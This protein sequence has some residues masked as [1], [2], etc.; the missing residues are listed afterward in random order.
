VYAKSDALLRDYQVSTSDAKLNGVSQDLYIEAHLYLERL[1]EQDI[2][3]RGGCSDWLSYWRGG[4]LEM[5]SFTQRATKV[6]VAVQYI[7]TDTWASM[8]ERH[9]ACTNETATAAIISQ[10]TRSGAPSEA[11]IT[12][13]NYEWVV[14]FC[15]NGGISSPAVC[16]ACPPNV[17]DSLCSRMGSGDVCTLADNQF[18]IAPCAQSVCA[19]RSERTS[20]TLLHALFEEKS[21]PPNINSAVLT[22]TSTTITAAVTL[23]DEG[24]IHCDA[25]KASAALPADTES[26]RIANFVA[27][28]DIVLGSHVANVIMLNL[29]PATTYKIFCYTESSQGVVMDSTKMTVQSAA[30]LASITTAC[31]KNMLVDLAMPSILEGTDYVDAISVATPFAPVATFIVDINLM[32]RTQLGDVALANSVIP[33]SL[34]FEPTNTGSDLLRKISIRR[35]VGSGSFYLE[36]IPRGGSGEF[37][38]TYPK[39]KDIA[40][41]GVFE[42]PPPPSILMVKF[43]DDGSCVKVEFNAKTDRAKLPHTFVCSA[44]FNF[45]GMDLSVCKWFSE[46]LVYVYP[47]RKVGDVKLAI[48]STVTVLPGRLKAVCTATSENEDPCANWVYMG[49]SSRE[50]S[51]PA[52]AVIPIV[53][54]SSSAQIGSCDSLPLD[55]TSS[56]GGGGRPWSIQ[57]TV[58]SSIGS[59]S[60]DAANIKTW[61]ET[62]YTFSP[63]KNVP[64]NLLLPGR[65]YNIVVKLCNFLLGCSQASHQVVVLNHVKPLVAIPGSILRTASRSVPFK[66]SSSA[67]VAGCGEGANAAPVSHTNI[68]LAWKVF[69]TTG[70]DSLRQAVVIQSASRDPSIMLLPRFTLQVNTLYEFQ[71]TA[72]SRIYFSSAVVSVKVLVEPS[73]VQAIILG[74]QS[75]SI[76]PLGHLEL[77][78]SDSYDED[79]DSTA[80][81]QSAKTAM[82]NSFV[83]EWS[84]HQIEPTLAESCSFTVSSAQPFPWIYGL[85]SS[86]VSPGTVSRVTVKITHTASGRSSSTDV[87]VTGI[88]ATAALVRASSET[89]LYINPEK[90]IKL[91]GEIQA[92]AA[93]TATW[94]IKGSGVENLSQVAMGSIAMDID[95]RSSSFYLSL[96]PNAIQQGQSYEFILTC[97]M[98]VGGAVSYASVLV[99]T[100]APPRPGTVLVNPYSGTEL[101][102]DFDISASLWQDQDLPLT[103]SLFYVDPLSKDASVVRSRSENSFG[104][105]KLPAGIA[106]NNFKVTCGV[107]VYDILDAM[108]TLVDENVVVNILALNAQELESLIES[109]I[110]ANSAD[111]GA[112]KQVIATGGSKMNT[113]ACSLAPDCAAL[114]RKHCSDVDHTCGSCI[115][116]YMG[117]AGSDNSPCV[118][119][120]TASTIGDA[121]GACIA[122]ADCPFSS[123]VSSLCIPVPEKAC[124][125]QCS[126]NGICKFIDTNTN[127]QLSSCSVTTTTCVAI[128][129][130]VD[131]FFGPL[132]HLL[133]QDMRSL[134]SARA[135][136][137]GSFKHLVLSEDPSVENAISWITSLKGLTQNPLELDDAA[138]HEVCALISSIAASARAVKLPYEQ[139]IPIFNIASAIVESVKKTAIYGSSRRKLSEDDAAILSASVDSISSAL[140]DDMVIGQDS[141]YIT[142]ENFRLTAVTSAVP[143]G[144]NVTISS[145]R[146]QLETLSNSA[147]PKIALSPMNTSVA[148]KMTLMVTPAKLAHSLD[149]SQ[150]QLVSIPNT[151]NLT[152]NLL[153]MRVSCAEGAQDNRVTFTI[154]HNG[155]EYFGPASSTVIQNFTTS[156]RRKHIMTHY[157]HCVGEVDTI[158]EVYCDG[159][160]KQIFSTCPQMQWQPRCRLLQNDVVGQE[161]NCTIIHALSS[162]LQTTCECSICSSSASAR[163]RRKLQS[164]DDV[165]VMAAMTEY[166]ARSFANVLSTA[167]SFNS[168]DD[169]MNTVIVI[170]SFGMIWV[171][172]PLVLIYLQMMHNLGRKRLAVKKKLADEGGITKTSNG[173]S[174][175]ENEGFKVIQKFQDYCVTLFPH[176][177]NEKDVFSR[178]RKELLE[179]H[180]VLSIFTEPNG[181]KKTIMAVHLMSNWTMICFVLCILYDLEF[182]NDNGQC[183][184]AETESVCNSQMS[185]FD[186]TEHMCEWDD[187]FRECNFKETDHTIR[188]FIFMSAL[189]CVLIVPMQ[190]MVDYIFLRV[191]LAPT[192]REIDV[193]QT[194]AGRVS[195]VLKKGS[196]R[197]TVVALDIGKHLVLGGI[198]RNRTDANRKKTLVGTPAVLFPE[199]TEEAIFAASEA[200]RKTPLAMAQVHQALEQ[201]FEFSVVDKFTSMDGRHDTALK[202]HLV[203]INAKLTLEERVMRFHEGLLKYRN[204]LR[205]RESV[206]RFDRNWQLNMVKPNAY[207]TA[208][209]KAGTRYFFSSKA[210]SQIT[211]RINFIAKRADTVAARVR[212]LPPSMRGAELLRLF[213]LDLAGTD[214]TTAKVLKRRVYKDLESHVVT[215]GM[216][217]LGV[218]FIFVLMLFMIFTVML[219]GS[220]KGREWQIAWCYTSFFTVVFEMSFNAF[221]EGFLIH[222]MVPILVTPEVKQMKIVVKKVVQNL[223]AEN[224][225]IQTRQKM[226]KK[227]AKTNNFSSTDYFFVSTLVAR[228]NPTLAESALILSYRDPTPGLT[229]RKWQPKPAEEGLQ[230]VTPEEVVRAMPGIDPRSQQ[231]RNYMRRTNMIRSFKSNIARFSSIFIALLL[232][233]ATLPIDAQ[234]TIVQLVQPLLAL[235]IAFVVMLASNHPEYFFTAIALL[236]L[237][238]GY[239]FLQMYKVRAFK[240]VH[241]L[242]ALDASAER[243]EASVKISGDAALQEAK[244]DSDSNVSSSDSRSSEPDTSDSSDS[245]IS[246]VSSS[247]IDEDDDNSGV[248]PFTVTSSL[249]DMDSIS[250]SGDSESKDDTK[251]IAELA[252]PTQLTLREIEAELTA[253]DAPAA[254]PLH[255]VQ[256]FTDY[257]APALKLTLRDIEEQL[258]G[259]GSSTYLEIGRQ[260]AELAITPRKRE[261]EREREFPAYLDSEE[262]DD[263]RPAE[264]TELD[265]S[266]P[267]EKRPWNLFFQ[268]GPSFVIPASL[269]VTET[270]AGDGDTSSVLAKDHDTDKD[271]SDDKNAN[272]ADGAESIAK[273]IE[274]SLF[275]DGQGT[276]KHEN[277]VEEVKI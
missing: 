111:M 275:L 80:M 103:Y 54:I 227:L 182:P 88:A 31:C 180:P 249:S 185:I 165:L 184:L 7:D 81:I 269:A 277:S 50:V 217:C 19:Q 104:T 191:I 32:Y 195:K 235:C 166:T 211:A 44:L 193:D 77:N 67:S 238:A 11:P 36:V 98:K 163:N 262:W 170:A 151:G 273:T 125:A 130:C 115:A 214:T 134:Q 13:G 65:R 29:I 107:Q 72:T 60:S 260:K 258:T 108:S 51:A 183:A 267:R 28:S 113:P 245:E 24:T 229:V 89:A 203:N 152:S 209:M 102:T 216:K 101:I 55:F 139:L 132:C 167:G 261:R 129:F 23:S 135:R 42:E 90:K 83:Y 82:L 222:Y 173:A 74:G 62:V 225:V 274:P 39:G 220:S 27:V 251:G 49:S 142:Q 250:N 244:A 123:C 168:M 78:A 205:T 187:D 21:P 128:C 94:S 86:S 270:A 79:V 20:A 3:A 175:P 150:R 73:P 192:A 212:K 61:L 18:V 179:D 157:H 141:V 164:S 272:D 91:F 149:A 114:F 228:D 148:L 92:A 119:E 17:I 190:L 169:I 186:T 133:A 52:K 188:S 178:I 230:H 121:G 237:F 63:P 199:D 126:G 213:I 243:Y 6:E 45:P 14:K 162:A 210:S 177:Y 5:H 105:T 93:A 276:I 221:I 109:S 236:V 140:I 95:S 226:K 204:S 144:E 37:F 127:E 161:A 112:I 48:G 106:F 207:S 96:T 253:L 194:E 99:E 38:I 118:G 41:I 206:Q 43:S 34:T 231:A 208:H 181:L 84:C 97:V 176:I 59:G 247:S 263:V 53:S 268:T 197:T 12:C 218:T 71:L 26:V 69:A 172:T 252:Q 239:I 147:A 254:I 47:S 156:C 100:N 248:S 4:A 143:A 241:P 201:Y 15:S 58:E 8:E 22:S 224:N 256:E 56:S 68:D 131:N 171:F 75:R 33:T 223:F 46:K 25:V 70:P 271:D 116:G 232:G 40:V 202:R 259:L 146:S 138:L 30:V 242:P 266:A 16:V 219:Y 137:I 145:P 257:R 155:I 233:M 57:Y 120:N 255:N 265:T 124:P 200:L 117:A 215:W 198:K 136:L 174:A 159:T 9:A 85:Q 2:Y 122:D 64:S 240:R 154:P 76:R 196:A 110:F 153:E 189:L 246:T 87:I 160:K 35:I 158:L 10:L 1:N 66:L 234:R 264:P